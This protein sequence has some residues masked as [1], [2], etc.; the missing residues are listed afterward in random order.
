M[1]TI[2]PDDIFCNVIDNIM[3]TGFRQGD[4]YFIIQREDEEAA[5]FYLEL[6]NQSQGCYDG[7]DKII[8]QDDEIVF[9]L[10]PMGQEALSTDAV[11]I[12]VN[13]REE[14]EY[15]KVIE[16]LELINRRLT[17]R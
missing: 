1:M 6:N 13:L 17:R 15:N 4:N 5:N 12:S 14:A 9:Q 8:I 10:N 11:V 3:V 2:K 7:L 16:E